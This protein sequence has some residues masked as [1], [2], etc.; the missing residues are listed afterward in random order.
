MK[1][2]AV[3]C[4]KVGQLLVRITRKR[5]EKKFS[6]LRWPQ[7]KFHSLVLYQGENRNGSEMSLTF[8]KPK[9]TREWQC[10]LF[11]SKA[12]W[13]NYQVISASKYNNP[14]G[15]E[16]VPPVHTELGKS[17]FRCWSAYTWN[18]LQQYIILRPLFSLEHYKR[19]YFDL[20][21]HICNVFGSHSSNAFSFRELSAC[22]SKL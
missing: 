13:W 18:E 21:S 7:T 15:T 14:N 11:I 4:H 9:K 22:I 6:E 12:S 3:S 5:Q 10:M 17:V 19:L 16:H 8:N 2:F 1:G 20:C